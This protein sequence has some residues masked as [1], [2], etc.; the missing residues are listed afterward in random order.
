MDHQNNYASYNQN[1]LAAVGARVIVV[2]L[3]SVNLAFKDSDKLLLHMFEADV[4]SY[5]VYINLAVY[6]VILMVLL[7]PLGIMMYS[8]AQM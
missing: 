1:G 8:S 4:R 5:H 3:H 7:I 6:T 2:Y